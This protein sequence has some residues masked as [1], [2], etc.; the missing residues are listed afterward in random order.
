MFLDE[1]KDYITDNTSLVYGTDLFIGKLPS[2]VLMS[3]VLQQM[4]TVDQYTLG[5]K[6]GYETIDTV[7]RIRGNQRET[8]TR[9]FA[10]NLRDTLEYISVDL[11]NYRIVR[12]AFSTHLYQLDGTDDNNN[13]IYVGVYTSI[14]ERK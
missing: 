4:N 12:G 6:L 13:Y 10:F 8:Q 14:I 1:L 5:N 9:A 2:G 3:A 11:P 7:I